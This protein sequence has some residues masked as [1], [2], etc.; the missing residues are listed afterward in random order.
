MTQIQEI[1]VNLKYCPQKVVVHG[2]NAQGVM[3]AGVALMVRSTYPKAY[4]EYV[5]HCVEFKD[6][7]EEL[8]GTIQVVECEDKNKVIINAF[9]QL[10][11]GVSRQQVD[12]D[13][14]RLCFRAINTYAKENGVTEIVMPKI[15]SGLGGG[16]WDIIKAIIEE[17]ST[18]FQPIVSIKSK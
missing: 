3:G 11:F 10:D 14:L 16:S 7:K 2:V 4:T 17:E 12:Y 9:T 5:T 1:D 18:D 6:K 15:G 13:A 8:L